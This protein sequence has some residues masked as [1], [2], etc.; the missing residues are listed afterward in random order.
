MSVLLARMLMASFPHLL[1]I[2]HMFSAI[3]T[4][5]ARLNGFDWISCNYYTV[6]IRFN[7]EMISLCL[8]VVFC[9]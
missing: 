8:L 1:N 7:S 5:S 9:K 2:Q 4:L 3:F 6:R